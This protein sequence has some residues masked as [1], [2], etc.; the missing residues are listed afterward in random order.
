MGRFGLTIILSILAL[1]L[2]TCGQTRDRVDL[3]PGTGLTINGDSILINRTTVEELE[4]ILNIKD[5]SN[6]SIRIWDGFNEKAMEEV[7]GTEVVKNI[8]FKTLDFE[9]VGDDSTNLKLQWVRISNSDNMDVIVNNKIKLGT[10]NPKIKESFKQTSTDYVSND[11][12]TYNF[13]SHGVSF[14][15]VDAADGLL[16]DE[17]SVHYTVK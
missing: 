7:S 15:L 17:L 1:V 13:Y 8:K 12:K 3:F 2:I 4:K 10:L 6:L 5:T 14:K 16:L 9:Y 11:Q